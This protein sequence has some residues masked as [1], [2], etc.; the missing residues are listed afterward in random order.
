MKKYFVF[1]LALLVA[2]NSAMAQRNKKSV[3]D[4]TTLPVWQNVEVTSQGTVYPHAN[5]I[6]YSN[7]N[8][9]EKWSY[10]QSSYCVSLNGDWQ[11]DVQYN[12]SG[13][14]DV[15]TKN[16]T[17]SGW[18]TVKEPSQKWISSGKVMKSAVVGDASHLPIQNNCVGTY[19]RTLTAPRDWASYQQFL[20]LR[21]TGS[22]CLY[23]NGEYVGYSQDSRLYSEFDITKYIVTGRENTIAIQVFAS[24]LN[25]VMEMNVDRGLNGINCDVQIILKN[26][27]S[28]ADYAIRADYNAKSKSANLELKIDVANVTRKGQYYVEVELWNPQGKIYEKMGKWAVFDKKNRL[29]LTMQQDFMAPQPWTAETPNLYSCV[30]RLRDKNMK[31]METVGSRFGFRTA[32]VQDG[33]LRVNGTPIKLRGVNYSDYNIAGTDGILSRERMRQDLLAMKQNN[34]NAVHTTYYSPADEYFY[35]LCDEY[36][37]YVLCDANL[38]PFSQKSKAIATDADYE[39]QFVWRMENMYEQL[40][41]HTS[42]IAWSLGAGQDNGTNMEA[43]YRALRQKDMARPVVYAGAQ[44]SDNTDIICATNS[45]VDDLKAFVAKHHT[46]PLLLTSY[47]SAQGNN[48]GGME[49]MWK[50]VRG[51]IVLQGGFFSSWNPV[52]YYDQNTHQD[53]TI[54]GLLSGD[55]TAKPYLTELRNIYRPFEVKLVR[56]AQD[57]GEFAVSNYLD[58]LSLHDYILEYTIFSNLKPRIIAGEVDVD[59][60]PGETKNFKLKVPRLTLYAGEELFIRFTVRQRQENAGLKHGTE[61][62]VME[63]ALPMHEVARKPQPDYAKAALSVEETGIEGHKHEIHV[64]NSNISLVYNLDKAAI[65]SYQYQGVNLVVDTPRLN[66]WRAATD[67]DNLDRNGSRLWRDLNPEQQRKEVVATNYRMLDKSTL[68]IDAMLR[69]LDADGNLLFDVKQSVVVLCSGDVL[70]DNE[71]MVSE[72][73]KTLPKVG[74]QMQVAAFDTVNW[75]GLEE[76]SYADRRQGVKM[77][78]Y[79]RPIDSMFFK[80]YRPQEAGNRADVRWISLTKGL[81]GLFIDMLDTNFNFSI[82]PYNDKQ[83]GSITDAADLRQQD[84][85]TLNIDYRQAAIGSAAAGIPVSDDL[86]LNGKTYHFRVHL[87]GYNTYDFAEQDFR[88]VLY[89]QMESSVLPMPVIAKD[90]ERFDGPMQITLTSA[91]PQAAIHYTLDGTTPTQQSPLYKKP[92]TINGST[93]IKTRAFKKGATP[94]FTATARYNFDYITKATFTNNANTPYNYNQENLLFNAETGDIND[95]SNGWLG[96]SGNDLE[97]VFDLSKS[98]ELQD[99]EMHFAHVPDAWTFA[100]T[101]VYVSVSSDGTHFGTPI[102]AK[103]TYDPADETMNNPQKITLRV[104]VER[105]DVRFVKI[106]ATNLGKIPV[107]HKAKGLKPWIMIDEV[108]LNEVIM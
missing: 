17:A 16:F 77:G 32:E 69:Y 96:F 79:K 68:S 70:I 99:V 103:I 65:V 94:S 36:G 39:D 74:L 105:R 14:P 104:N 45:N 31:V 60:A 92:F 89:P 22:Y 25:Q 49:A 34:I 106:L 20:R 4:E 88:R 82:Y 87:R 15:T 51:N 37:I 84:S 47:G 46:R 8:G 53:V 80:Y 30:I 61:L 67:N 62:A 90:R 6:P 28:V 21:I 18:R 23:V 11:L 57:H 59:L 41:N 64:S 9:I 10:G 63:Y 72:H 108:T 27:V 91:T 24:G 48:L 97:V 56:M 29:T 107:W 81:T 55:G 58:F 54:P 43:A 35:E 13:A 75:M 85:Y 52:T 50:T 102:A 5:V 73:I 71:V 44:Y 66:F 93:V 83:L 40:K 100:P 7:E 101:H 95:L 98:I 42:I 19:I 78:T 76:E 1:L 2:L 26:A 38:V 86:L 12:V 33:L 3:N